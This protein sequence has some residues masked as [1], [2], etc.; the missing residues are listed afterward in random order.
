MQ[1]FLKDLIFLSGPDIP[2]ANS[3]N[4]LYRSPKLIIQVILYFIHYI[5]KIFAA[6]IDLNYKDV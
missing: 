3:I 6:L 2:V 1:D 4:N 5:I